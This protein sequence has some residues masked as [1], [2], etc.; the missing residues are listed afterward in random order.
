M[1]FISAAVLLACSVGH[2][3]SYFISTVAG[4]VAP[5]TPPQG[6][7]NI[8][9]PYGLA[10]DAAGNLYIADTLNDQIWTFINGTARVIAGTWAPNSGPALNYP[11]AVAVD[12]SGDVIIADTDNNAVIIGLKSGVIAV[13]F[14][15]PNA[16]AV[17]AAGNIYVA[18]SNNQTIRKISGGTIVTLAGNGT[19][20][21]TGDNGPA[22]AAQL[23]LPSGVAVD[24]AGNVYISDFGNNVVR[25]V[26]AAG[27]ITTIAGNGRFGFSGDGGSAAQASLN[28]PLGL[29][30][31]PS[32]NLYIA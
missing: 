11:V 28:G 30:I 25:R 3:Q 20:G 32:G 15:R 29:A 4:G 2:A 16:V 21:Y 5:P 31:D 27:T 7:T 19:S 17:D 12:A 6:T 23:N 26:T 18:D 8:A 10:L 24:S 13:G 1:K 14:N 22:T 9:L